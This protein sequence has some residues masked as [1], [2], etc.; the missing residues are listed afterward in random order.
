VEILMANLKE[1]QLITDRIVEQIGPSGLD[2][3]KENDRVFFLVFGF[4]G[5]ISNGG[6]ASFFYNSPANEY[7]ETLQALRLLGL[8]TFAD[9]LEQ[10]AGLL[11]LGEVPRSVEERNDIIVKLPEDIATDEQFDELFRQYVDQGG[12]DHVLDVLERWYVQS[13]A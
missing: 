12:D 9:L 11:F 3:L 10:A 7:S 8:S 2:S 13:K 1:L 4:A 6:F 5:V